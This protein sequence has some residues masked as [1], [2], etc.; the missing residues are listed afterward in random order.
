[1]SK[2]LDLTSFAMGK[3][4]SR[5]RGEPYTV[6]SAR[7]TVRQRDEIRSRADKM[8]V[9]VSDLILLGLAAVLAQPDGQELKV[10]AA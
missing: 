7:M 3:L 1:M 2:E 4:S 9:A 5:Q 8:G 10:L 6:I